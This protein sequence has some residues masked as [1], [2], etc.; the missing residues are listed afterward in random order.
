[1]ARMLWRAQ[2]SMICSKSPC[3]LTVAV[4]SD[5]QR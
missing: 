1:M 5:S 2:A 3:F 4:F